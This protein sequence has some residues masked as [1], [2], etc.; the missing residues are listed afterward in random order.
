MGAA[1]ASSPGR[2]PAGNQTGHRFGPLTAY[3][4]VATLFH[5]AHPNRSPEDTSGSLRDRSLL[6]T[7]LRGHQLV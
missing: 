7:D 3:G 2:G 1:D 6:L 4:R 5:A